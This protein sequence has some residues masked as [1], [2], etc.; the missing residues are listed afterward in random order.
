MDLQTQVQGQ[1]NT[2]EVQA[3][4]VLREFTQHPD[5]NYDETFNPVVKPVLIH[6]VLSIALS[7]A[8]PIHQLDVKNAFLHGMLT[9]TV[10]STQPTSFFDPG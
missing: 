5:V 2:Q 4:M 1:W 7:W 6:I 8:W 3:R 9:E 10:Y